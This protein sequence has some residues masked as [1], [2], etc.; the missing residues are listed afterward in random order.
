MPAGAT[1]EPIA[2]TTL[3]S[4]NNTV[5][6]SNIPAT[7]TD[8]MLIINATRPAGFDDGS[9]RLNGDTGSNYSTTLLQGNGSTASSNRYSNQTLALNLL[10]SAEYSTNIVHIMNY[11][12]TTTYKTFFTRANVAG[13][14]IRANVSVWRSTAAIT[15]VT[16]INSSSSNFGAGSTFTLYGI[17][18]A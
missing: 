10:F 1:Y 17:A 14:N 11:S 9:V 4:A 15:S 6:F 5:T 8:L 3:G 2:T 7:Y 16:L 13:D 18:A 12:N